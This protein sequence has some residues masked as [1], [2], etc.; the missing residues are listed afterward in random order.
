MKKTKME[1]QLEAWLLAN[2]AEA[3]NREEVREKRH[4]ESMEKKETAIKVYESFMSK[5]LD[6]L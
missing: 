4:K 1:R 3:Q 5:L 2:Q 6:K